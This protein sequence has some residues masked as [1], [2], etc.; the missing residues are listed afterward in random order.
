MLHVKISLAFLNWSF[1]IFVQYSLMAFRSTL[2]SEP[3][4]TATLMYIIW[5]KGYDLGPS[6]FFNVD[7]STGPRFWFNYTSILC[8][9]SLSA[10][11]CGQGTTFRGL[12]YY[13]GP[14]IKRRLSGLTTSLFTHGAILLSLSYALTAKYLIHTI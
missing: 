14:Q 3:L 4:P 8:V 10:M 2:L 1:A 11:M 13:K 6:M 5:P 12:F 9:L 7:P